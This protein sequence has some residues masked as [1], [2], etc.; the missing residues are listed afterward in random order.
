MIDGSGPMTVW[1][2]VVESTAGQCTA[3]PH[4]TPS[5]NHLHI[6][7]YHLIAVLY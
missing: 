3:N 7:Y 6:D 2:S 5:G 1:L 4:L